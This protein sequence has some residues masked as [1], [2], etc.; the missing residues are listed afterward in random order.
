MGQKTDRVETDAL[1]ELMYFGKIRGV[2]L[3]MTERLF[4]NDNSF[5]SGAIMSKIVSDFPK[6]TLVSK[7]HK[8][9]HSCEKQIDSQLLE[10][11]RESSIQI[12]QS[13]LHHQNIFQLI[14]HYTQW[15]NKLPYASMIP[16]GHIVKVCYWGHWMMQDFLIHTKLYRM[17]QNQR[18][19][20][21]RITSIYHWLHKV[22]SNRNGSWSAC[23]R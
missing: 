15:D 14:R 6:A 23:H 12:F 10:R 16:A 8:K 2:N 17:L 9:E 13:M 11:S 4:S 1:F 7:T 20:V 5:F 21:V 3:H 22:F 19:K 18:P